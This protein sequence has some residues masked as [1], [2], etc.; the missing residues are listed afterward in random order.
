MDL[1]EIQRVI[2]E[3]IQNA[4]DVEWPDYHKWRADA[5]A[6]VQQIKDHAQD[7]WHDTLLG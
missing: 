3:A 5:E 6:V 1:T 4:T 2:E 7:E